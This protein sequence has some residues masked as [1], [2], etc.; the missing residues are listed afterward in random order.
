MTAEAN[1]SIPP[2]PS[3]PNSTN[4]KG[5]DARASA[6]LSSPS[7]VSYSSTGE[8]SSLSRRRESVL[9]WPFTILAANVSFLLHIFHP[10]LPLP[11]TCSLS[12]SLS[13][14][15]LHQ[16]QVPSLALSGMFVVLAEPLTVRHWQQAGWPPSLGWWGKG[17]RVL[18]T[19][20]KLVWV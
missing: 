17:S 5:C 12:L 1:T 4:N 3:H 6:S 10:P 20:D 16:C 2:S 18:H 13:L 8:E 11:E 7:T 19:T 9:I 14:V 15:T